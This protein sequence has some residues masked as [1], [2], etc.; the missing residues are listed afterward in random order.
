MKWLVCGG[1]EFRDRTWAYEFLDS[2]ARIDPPDYVIH[3]NCRGGDLIADEWAA[4][5]GIQPV[6][7][8]AL[9]GYWGN[10]KAGPIRNGA[11]AGLEPH[12]V[13][14]LPGGAGTANMVRIAKARGIRVIEA[15]K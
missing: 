10:K 8:R 14:A 13:I 6:A 4:S 11:M 7:C 9:W 5:R 2:Q 3:G 1:R 12:L 15:K